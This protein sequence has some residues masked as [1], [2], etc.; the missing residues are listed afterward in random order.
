MAEMT[1]ER[2]AE[3]SEEIFA[4]WVKALGVETVEVGEGRV[5]LRMP[6]DPDVTRQG[7][8]GGGVVSGQ[9]VA[10]A[11]DTASVLALIALND[12]LRPC[13]TVDI[14]THF[15]RPLPEGEAEIMVEAVS[16]GRRMAVTRVEIRAAGAAKLSA[17]ATL[18]FAYLDA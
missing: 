2:L 4:P 12:A 3:V 7:G 5:R 13:T 6:G 11:A 18:T 1:L 15:A 16:N 8:P 17:V 14:T 10:A 9:A